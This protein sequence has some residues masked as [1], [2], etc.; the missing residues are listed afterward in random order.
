MISTY[1]DQIFYL[2]LWSYGFVKLC[3]AVFLPSVCVLDIENNFLYLGE[4]LYYDKC[5]SAGVL[6]SLAVV[7][8]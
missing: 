5:R 2:T 8:S 1:I 3:H 6:G 4:A 7:E